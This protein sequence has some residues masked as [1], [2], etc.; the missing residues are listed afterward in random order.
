MVKVTCFQVL[1]YCNKEIYPEITLSF[2]RRKNRQ[3][4]DSSQ[5][6]QYHHVLTGKLETTTKNHQNFFSDRSRLQRL[7]E[8]VFCRVFFLLKGSFSF[9]AKILL[10]GVC[11]LVEVFFRILSALYIIKYLDTTVVMVWCNIKTPELK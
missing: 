11:L 6:Q 8:P 1:P 10:K 9:F 7:P 3:I 2:V 5:S 4:S